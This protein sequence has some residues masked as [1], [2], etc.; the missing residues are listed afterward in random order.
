MRRT[1]E[2]RVFGGSPLATLAVAT[3][4][5]TSA[6][7]VFAVCSPIA[8]WSKFNCAWRR[9]GQVIRRHHPTPDD[10]GFRL[11]RPENLK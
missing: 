7:E 11:S 3:T 1:R 2:D 9:I 6:I 5:P 10:I 8:A 4:S